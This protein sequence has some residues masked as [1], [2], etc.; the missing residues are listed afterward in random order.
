MRVSPAAFLRLTERYVV[1]FVIGIVLLYKCLNWTS[2]MR[3]SNS[4]QRGWSL[5]IDMVSLRARDVEDGGITIEEGSPLARTF[6]VE[7]TVQPPP[8][9]YVHPPR[10]REYDVEKGYQLGTRNET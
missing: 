7:S 6:S 5:R 4:G 3:Q 8:P 9:R 10:Y 2:R 1:I